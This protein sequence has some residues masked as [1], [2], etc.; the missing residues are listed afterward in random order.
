MNTSVRLL[1]VSFII[2]L[3]LAA[4]I[5]MTSCENVRC[6]SPPFDKHKC[7]RVE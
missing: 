4:S 1:L 3:V 7:P 2:L 6:P 5:A